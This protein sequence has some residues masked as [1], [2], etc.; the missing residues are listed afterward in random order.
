MLM[1]VQAH[2]PTKEIQNPREWEGRNELRERENKY[3]NWELVKVLSR[4]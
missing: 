3:G 2:F 4:L 1:H